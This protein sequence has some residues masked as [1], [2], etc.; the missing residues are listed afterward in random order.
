MKKKYTKPSI[1]KVELNHEQAILGTCS[2]DITDIKESDPVYCRG[3]PSAQLCKQ[4]STS[5][6][7]GA[8]S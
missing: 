4:H 6:D 2:T 7:S 5:G 8:L 3:T 1:V